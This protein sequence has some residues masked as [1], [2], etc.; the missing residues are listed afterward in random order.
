MLVS[1]YS[2]SVDIACS[3]TSGLG[4]SWLPLSRLHSKLVDWSGCPSIGSFI[5]LPRSRVEI[6]FPVSPESTG[7]G[8]S[9]FDARTARLKSS[10]SLCSSSLNFY[11]RVLR[12]RQSSL[13][14]TAKHESLLRFSLVM[15]AF[16]WRMS[17]RTF[18]TSTCTLS[19][20]NLNLSSLS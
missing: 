17:W 12:S 19:R 20:K 5:S 6:T 11:S 16:I 8:A 7:C 10:C 14:V 1:D 13:V 15:S 4:T 9:A 18:L 2:H 3:L